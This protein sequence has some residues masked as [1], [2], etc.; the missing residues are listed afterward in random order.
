MAHIRWILYHSG[1]IC[2][3]Q[4]DIFSQYCKLYV[5]CPSFAWDQLKFSCRMIYSML[6]WQSSSV[7]KN[8]L[9]QN[10]NKSLTRC[11]NYE[12]QFFSGFIQLI[13]ESQFCIVSCFFL[14]TKKRFSLIRKRLR[15]RSASLSEL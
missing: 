12:V 9:V 15:N 7:Q 10:Q 1:T 14:Q 11:G 2:N 4:A 13:L 8:F 3:I 5:L 6:S